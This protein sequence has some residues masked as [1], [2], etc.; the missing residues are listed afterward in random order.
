MIVLGLIKDPRILIFDEATSALDE[1][2]EKDLGQI[3]GNGE[4]EVTWL[5]KGSRGSAVKLSAYH[6]KGGRTNLTVK[7]R[8]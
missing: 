1:K 2:N 8:R 3:S 7:L 4:T 5:V 6:P